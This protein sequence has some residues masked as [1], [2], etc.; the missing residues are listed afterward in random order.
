MAKKRITSVDLSW[1]IS[2]QL[3]DLGK[4]RSRTAIAVV[5]DEN[6][7]WRA[8]VDNRGRRFLTAVDER[9]LA[10]IQRRLRVVYELRY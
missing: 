9:R 3:F 1:I 6:D 10:E 7:G 8:I 4:H 5:P 2:E